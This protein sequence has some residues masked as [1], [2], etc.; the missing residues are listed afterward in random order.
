MR[1]SEEKPQVHTSSGYNMFSMLTTC[2]PYNLAILASTT[3][4]CHTHW[5]WR[6]G[7]HRFHP[8]HMDGT[9]GIH[10]HTHLN[11]QPPI[12]SESHE[13]FSD[14]ATDFTTQAATLETTET[15]INWR[16]TCQPPL[17]GIRPVLFTYW[18]IMVEKGDGEGTSV[19][20]TQD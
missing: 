1:M 9:I 4:I 3:P 12:Q 2:C 20:G 11:S 10:T 7:S 16:R 14:N 8:S 6:N 5:I 17:E 15:C 18:R 19:N 13:I